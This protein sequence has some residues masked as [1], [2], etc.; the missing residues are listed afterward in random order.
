MADENP[1]DKYI[2][3]NPIMAGAWLGSVRYALGREDVMAAFRSDTGFHWTPGKSVLDRMVD[4]ATGVPVAFLQAFAKWHNE[5]IWGEENGEPIDAPDCPT[6]D[7]A[8][9]A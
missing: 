7:S 3:E 8:E 4:D 1:L 6:R 5:H 2:P 9:S